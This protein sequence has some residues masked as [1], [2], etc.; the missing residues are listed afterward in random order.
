MHWAQTIPGI[1]PAD[2]RRAES[3]QE[4]KARLNAE[5]AELKERIVTE[6]AQLVDEEVSL[7]RKI[8][9]QKKWVGLS[10]PPAIAAMDYPTLCR[11]LEGKAESVP[12]A[13]AATEKNIGEL[14]D[15]IHE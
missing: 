13:V 6:L 3:I 10:F 4:R 7:Y 1:S 14:P 11:L 12:G 15:T 5:A 2:R 9:R 8:A